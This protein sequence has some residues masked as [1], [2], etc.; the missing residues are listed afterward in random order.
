MYFDGRSV[1][2]FR[3]LTYYY[4]R[5]L[6]IDEL[7]RLRIAFVDKDEPA[8]AM[9]ELPTAYIAYRYCNLKQFSSA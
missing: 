4:G 5:R 3:Y 7:V 8:N 9:D 2:Y 6:K 1:V